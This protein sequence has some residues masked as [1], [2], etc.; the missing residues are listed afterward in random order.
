[1]SRPARFEHHRWLGDKRV[2]V[3]HDLDRAAPACG[4]EELLASERFTT[5]GPDRLPEARNRGYRPCRHCAAPTG[6]D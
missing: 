4:L 2:Q 1:M 3:V 5:F 6:Q